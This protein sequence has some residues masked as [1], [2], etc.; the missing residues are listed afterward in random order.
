MAGNVIG[1]L[2]GPMRELGIELPL[3]LELHQIFADVERTGRHMSR[4]F[5][6]QQMWVLPLEHQAATRGR[7]DDIVAGIH[8]GLQ[9]IE[10]GNRLLQNGGRIP[11]LKERHPTTLLFRAHHLHPVLLQHLDGRLPH[12]RLVIVDQARGEQRDLCHGR[13]GGPPR[14]M[15]TRPLQP[16][17]KR[18]FLKFHQLTLPMDAEHPVQDIA[19]PRCPVR[20]I[21][22]RG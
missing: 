12:L 14:H 18:L 13:F 17:R 20:P 9:S 3:F 15:P 1:D 10:I 8:V 4:L 21:H 22:Q 6:R 7:H 2:S 5:R 19:Y 11:G 16:V